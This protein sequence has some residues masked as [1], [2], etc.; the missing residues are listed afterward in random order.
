MTLHRDR[1]HRLVAEAMD[2]LACARPLFHS[3]ADFQLALGW[4]IQ[5]QHPAARIWSGGQA[6]T[7]DRE[8]G[9]PQGVAPDGT[10]A[11]GAR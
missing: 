3:E 4:T 11:R 7:G 5:A 6:A 2:E 10:P 8:H 9:R 1:L